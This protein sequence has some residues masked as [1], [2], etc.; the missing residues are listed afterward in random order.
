[1]IGHAKLLANRV[2]AGDRR[3]GGLSHLEHVEDVVVFEK[4]EET[5]ELIARGAFL[6]VVKLARLT[7]HLEPGPRL[8]DEPDRNDLFGDAARRR[9]VGEASH[10]RHRG[11]EKV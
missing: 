5:S 10:Q 2:V 1:L 4:L 11:G 8:L 9:P 6:S 7:P 3:V